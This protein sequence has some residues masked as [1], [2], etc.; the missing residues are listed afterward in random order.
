VETSKPSAGIP[1]SFRLLTRKPYPDSASRTLSG[2]SDLVQELQP[3]GEVGI[4]ST[5]TLG[6]SLPV[7]DKIRTVKRAPE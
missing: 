7:P 5:V 1:A 6:L 2:L 4:N 3:L